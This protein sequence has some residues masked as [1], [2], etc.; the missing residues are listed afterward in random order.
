MRKLAV[1]VL[2][3]LTVLGCRKSERDAAGDVLIAEAT[4][5]QG[6]TTS[7]TTD[8][9][10]D[11]IYSWP[12]EFL[13]AIRARH[14]QL[15]Y[16]NSFEAKSWEA[17]RKRQGWKEVTRYRVPG[18]PEQLQTDPTKRQPKKTHDLFIDFPREMIVYRKN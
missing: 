12:K 13:P 6:A 17:R 1:V 4:T 14:P 16:F 7:D 9:I 2:V 11:T 8:M 10:V 5:A 3:C 18:R 15:V